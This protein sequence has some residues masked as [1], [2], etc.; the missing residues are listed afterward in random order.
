MDNRQIASEETLREWLKSLDP[1]LDVIY[2]PWAERYSLICNWPQADPRW[3]LFQSGEIGAHY[4]SLGWLCKDMGDA[5]SVPLNLDECTN[6]VL[7]RLASCDNTTRDWK[8]RLKDSI[9]HNRKVKDDRK[10]IALERTEEIASSLRK[11]VGH[12]E[13]A[14]MERIFDEVSKGVI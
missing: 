12:T 4:D 14:K 10:K 3:A 2:L 7:E 5:D 1:L 11:M 9:V 6:V 13:E 8:I